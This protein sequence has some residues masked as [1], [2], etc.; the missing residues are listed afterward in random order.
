MEEERDEVSRIL[1]TLEE[2]ELISL[3]EHLKCNAPVGGFASKPRRTLIRLVETTLDEI[4]EG[5]ESESYQQY[6]QQVLSHLVSLKSAPEETEAE[7]VVQE[8]SE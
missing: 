4:E 2:K 5:E 7:I 3:C 6:L 1:L 8:T